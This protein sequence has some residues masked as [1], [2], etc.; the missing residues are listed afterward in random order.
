MVKELHIISQ[1]FDFTK[2]KACYADNLNNCKSQSQITKRV[3]K[4]GYKKFQIRGAKQQELEKNHSYIQ[5]FALAFTRFL[6]LKI[7]SIS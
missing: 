1:S 3:L 7:V 2:T 5:T 4:E 6:E